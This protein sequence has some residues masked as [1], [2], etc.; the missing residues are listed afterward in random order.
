[1]T[2]TTRS[3]AR[4]AALLLLLAGVALSQP[5]RAEPVKFALDPEHLSIAFLVH[6]LGFADVLGL[7]LKAEGSFTFDDAVPM[8]RD[9]EVSINAASVFSNHKARDKHLRSDAFLWARK[10]PKIIFTG[11]ASKQTGP[12]T[13]TVTGD[14]TI[15]GIAKP[16]T[17]DVVWNKSGVYPFGDEHE[18]VG[19]SIRT[20]FKRTDFGMSYAAAN[21]W[22]GD[23][24]EVIIEFEAKRVD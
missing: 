15:R 10:Y 22:V 2:R 17:L 12:T 14:L 18:T 16:V 4:A 23:D 7:F 8:V 1:M 5:A 9:I 6:H 13:G 11:T 21:G 3:I 19:I 24:V 20:T